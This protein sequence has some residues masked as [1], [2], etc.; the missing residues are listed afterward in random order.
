MREQRA[1]HTSISRRATATADEHL[2]QALLLPEASWHRAGHSSGIHPEDQPYQS[3]T[4]RRSLPPQS[5]QAEEEGDNPPRTRSSAIRRYVT[6][7]PIPPPRPPRRRWHPLVRIGLTGVAI[8][9]C[10][11]ALLTIPTAYQRWQDDLHYGYPRTYQ[12][13]AAVGHSDSASHPSHFLAINWHGHLDV[14]ELAGGDPSKAT[15][16]TGP[17][18]YQPDADLVPV[19]LSFE[20]V[21]QD[22]RPDL[23]LHFEGQIVVFLNTGKTF[24]A[25]HS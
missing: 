3:E 22:G 21:N 2:Q 20:D 14:I 9:V 19:T 6:T 25:S 23:V 18:L 5:V 1:Q 24:K 8:V 15:I 13:D 16:Y 10:T 11:M 17:T 4:L 12:T 7:T